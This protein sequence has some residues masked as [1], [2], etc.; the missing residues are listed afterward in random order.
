[1]SDFFNLE[2]DAP[3]RRLVYT[4]AIMLVIVPLVTSGQVLWPLH[5]SDI[6]WRYGAANSLSSMLIMPF[7]G[8]ALMALMARATENKNVSRL[9]GLFSA[10]FVIG[11]L[12]SLALFALDALQLKTIVTSAQEEAF[13]ATSARIVLS[14][15][16]F[17]VGFFVLM[18]TA[19]K[20]QRPA[21]PAS[22]KGPKKADES[23]GLIVGQ[24]G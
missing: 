23:V 3:G 14:T 8:L 24:E 16:I 6:R 2:D 10:V 13:Q 11:L 12:G 1:M 21:I 5:L 20:S 7:L 15:L 22:R 19:F 4:T 9:V 17:T 18:I